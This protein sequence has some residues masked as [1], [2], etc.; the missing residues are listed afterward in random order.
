MRRGAVPDAEGMATRRVPAVRFWPLAALAFLLLTLEGLPVS[1]RRAAGLRLAGVAAS[2]LLLAGAAT[3]ACSESGGL[4]A[5]RRVVTSEAADG[6][7]EVVFRDAEPPSI[8]LNGSTITRL[9]ETEGVPTRVPIGIDSG[10]AA[11]NAQ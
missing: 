5:V 8:T 4:P 3:P 9:W 2:G 6:K 11:G 1:R 7:G 10:A